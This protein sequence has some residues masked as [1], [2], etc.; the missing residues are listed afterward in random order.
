MPRTDGR[1]LASLLLL[2]MCTHG[3]DQTNL[4][5]N[6][7]RH[8]EDVDAVQVPL[9]MARLKQYLDKD[10]GYKDKDGGYFN[11]KAGTYTDEEGGVLD[12]WKGYTFTDGSYKSQFGDYWDEKT[13]TFQ[14][15]NGKTIKSSD[16]TSEEAIK[17]IRDNVEKND[18]YYKY[19]IVKSM[20]DEIKK[21][22][23]GAAANTAK[24][25]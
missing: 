3:T 13:K 2:L 4:D 20:I 16:R 11:P 1:L 8:D 25:P 21:E 7:K 12:N 19:Y 14:L 24:H 9:E 23:P 10:G 22:H 5:K 15:A 6:K 18:G 17:L